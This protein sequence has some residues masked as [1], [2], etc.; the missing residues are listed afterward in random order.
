MWLCPDLP[1]H[2][3]T[4]SA[5]Q[6][7]LNHPAPFGQSPFPADSAAG[8]FEKGPGQQPEHPTV[9]GPCPPALLLPPPTEQELSAVH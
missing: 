8:G 4:L 5:H 2:L 7:Y 3:V 6:G 9:M 1:G